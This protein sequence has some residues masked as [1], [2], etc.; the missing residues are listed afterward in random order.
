M[1]SI[2]CQRQQR[3]VE[4]TLAIDGQQG[5]LYD[6]VIGGTFHD[7]ASGSDS[8]QNIFVYIAREG[9]KFFRVTQPLPNS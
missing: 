6:D 9:R 2:E 5:K 3:Q 4:S 8:P 1:K 7:A